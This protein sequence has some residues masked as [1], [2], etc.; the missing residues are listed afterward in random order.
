MGNE[1]GT[2]M[3]ESFA[4]GK[5]AMHVQT[6]A[7]QGAFMAGAEAGGWELDART[8]PAFG[9]KPVVPTN[10]GSMLSIFASDPAEQAASWKLVKWMTSERAYEVI[11]TGIGYL[12]LRSSM[13]EEGGPLHEWVEANPLVKP[14]LEQLDDLEPWVSY[15]GDSYI[16]VDTLLATA[17]EESIF[18]GADPAEALGEA[19][20]RAQDL[21]ED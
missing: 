16:Q 7:L 3:Y 12:P 17:I 1:D 10:S 15:P 18:F 21:I 2:T 20:K 4:A 11:S 5:T 8:L 6:S 14:N 19:A 9:D 13:T